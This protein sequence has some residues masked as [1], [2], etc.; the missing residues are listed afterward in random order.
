[1]PKEYLANY[2]KLVEPDERHTIAFFVEAMKRAQSDEPILFFGVGP[3]L[4]HVFLAACKAS[5]IHLGDYLP[6]NLREI[7]RWIEHD[8]D[9]HDWRAFVHYTLACEGV[10]N[11]T[12]EEII[13]RE[14][15][16]RAKI[17]KLI[18]VDIRSDHPLGRKNARLY[19]TVISAYCADSVTGDRAVWETYIRRIAALVR[20]GGTLIIAAL[21]NAR[22]YL[23][24]GKP[25]PSANIGEEDL[26]VVLGSCFERGDL[27]ILV[28]EVPECEP[29][30][31]SSIVLARAHR[32]SIAP[33]A[34]SRVCATQP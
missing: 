6:A 2:Y 32:H 23:V 16:T 27:A 15:V 25:F 30:G 9:A 17:K 13:R 5:E 20:P 19:G 33:A 31:Y 24:D 34:S 11:P 21:R 18:E 29:Q 14:E 8:R 28:C 7:E 22:H 4:H 3:T 12:G 26:R 1:V 10:A